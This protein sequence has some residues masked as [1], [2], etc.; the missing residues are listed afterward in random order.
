MQIVEDIAWSIC[1]QQA[2]RPPPTK[3]GPLALPG[4]GNN[5]RP[6]LPGMQPRDTSASPFFTVRNVTF[7]QLE[8][9]R[10]EKSA[11]WRLCAKRALKLGTEDLTA[12][13]PSHWATK[14]V[15]PSEGFPTGSS[16]CGGSTGGIGGRRPGGAS[17]C[18]ASLERAGIGGGEHEG[19]VV[20]AGDSFAGGQRRY[21]GAADH[22]LCVL[23]V[24]VCSDI[25]RCPEGKPARRWLLCLFTLCFLSCPVLACTQ[26]TQV[27]GGKS[28]CGP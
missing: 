3:G 28:A 2:Q 13:A 24:S 14:L 21:Q 26:V 15:K 11:T 1:R 18:M 22:R 17:C 10:T 8:T 27:S 9:A 25:D 16:R 4:Q 23:G 19:P 20:P 5:L 7:L 6:P 12:P